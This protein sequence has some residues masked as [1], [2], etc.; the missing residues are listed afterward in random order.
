MGL[1]IMWN[2]LDWVWVHR[3]PKKTQEIIQNSN[4]RLVKEVSEVHKKCI[5]HKLRE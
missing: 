1:K 5:E 3:T 4:W 2:S